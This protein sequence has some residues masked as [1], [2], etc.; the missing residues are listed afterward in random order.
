MAMMKV[1]DIN[2]GSAGNSQSNPNVI[3][4]K[5]MEANA[6]LQNQR[7]KEIQQAQT[8]TYTPTSKVAETPSYD[9][10][11][12]VEALAKLNNDKYSALKEALLASKQRADDMAN[13]SYMR[14]LRQWNKVYNGNAGR[15]NGAGLSNKF[16]LMAGRDSVLRDNE[17]DYLTNLASLTSGKYDDMSNIASM[18]QGYDSN[19]INNLIKYFR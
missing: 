7:A 4:N 17:T 3:I 5:A 16:N 2:A 6:N 1:D 12:L 10:S 18:M 14:N 15:L 11:G 9:Y 8:P 19:T 13:N